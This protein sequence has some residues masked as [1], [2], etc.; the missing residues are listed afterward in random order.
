MTER[1]R[2]G[3]IFFLFCAAVAIFLGLR[4]SSVCA[5]GV[6]RGIDLAVSKLIPSLFPFMVISDMIVNTQASLVLSRIIGKPFSK[7][8]AISSEGGAAFVFG[9]LFGFPVGILFAIGLYEDGRIDRRELSR[10]S[11]FVS[12]PSPAFFVSAVGEG[13]FGSAQFGLATYLCALFANIIIGVA[14]RGLFLASAG[15]YLCARG[16]GERA[17]GGNAFIGAVTSSAKALLSI[18]SFV[19]FFSMI[20][21]VIEYLLEPIIK[22]EVFFA[23]FFGSME[24]TGGV[25]RASM[26]GAYGAPIAAAILGF[27]GISVLCQFLSVTRS[28]KLPIGG[29]LLAKLF[30]A[31]MGF[32]SSSL[33]LKFFGDSFNIGEPSVPSFALY[34]ENRLTL[35]LFAL[36]LC[37]CFIALRAEK[38]KIFKKTIYKN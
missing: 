31:A 18:S 23:L 3:Q 13:L 26:L 15:E 38:E 12:M 28:C 36:F 24:M 1:R 37:A 22:N 4:Y 11:L 30:L 35:A 6:S 19:V 9:M 7:L 2:Y 32:L 14:T 10:L 5:Q 20:C 8:F 27:S 29:Y 33:L 25:A 34:G 16:R 17:K 21:E